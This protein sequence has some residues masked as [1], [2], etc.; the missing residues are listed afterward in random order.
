MKKIFLPIALLSMTAAYALENTST[1]A[2]EPTVEELEAQQAMLQK[3]GEQLAS[4]LLKNPEISAWHDR[5]SDD[6]IKEFHDLCVQYATLNIVAQNQF[7]PH[8]D[9]LFTRLT[10]VTGN[11]YWSLQI[12]YASKATHEAQQD[13]LVDEVDNDAD[14]DDAE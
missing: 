12:N 5:A 14:G 11:P 4:H 8:Y 13:A 10:E 9:E 1:S 3:L 6:Q 2:V 7:A